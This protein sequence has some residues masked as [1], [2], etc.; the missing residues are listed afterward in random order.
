[1]NNVFIPQK[2]CPNYEAK[3]ANSVDPDQTAPLL[4]DQTYQSK[5]LGSLQHKCMYDHIMI[6][7][8]QSL[9]LKIS[10]KFRDKNQ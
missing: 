9:A 8:R 2:T 3:M 10:E 6:I 5:N 1:M 4:F 7:N